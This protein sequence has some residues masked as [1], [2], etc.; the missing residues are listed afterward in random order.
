MILDGI[1]FVLFDLQET[2][3]IIWNPVTSEDSAYPE[4]HM[5]I[6]LFESIIPQ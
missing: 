1:K 3:F 5:G 4:N 6:K 2:E